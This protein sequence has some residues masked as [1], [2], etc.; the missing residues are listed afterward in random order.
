MCRISKKNRVINTDIQS[1]S[2]D[3]YCQPLFINHHRNDQ[4]LSVI[5]AYYFHLFLGTADL[6]VSGDNDNI[7]NMLKPCN[8]IWLHVA[9]L[10][11]TICM[12]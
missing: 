1:P 7:S 3:A 4:P 9:R 2:D 12:S 5:L 11:Q 6:K 8:R 10:C